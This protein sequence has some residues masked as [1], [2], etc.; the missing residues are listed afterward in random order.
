MAV[1][2]W[3]GFI[4][5]AFAGLGW[6]MAFHLSPP[7]RHARVRAWLLSWSWR[8]LVLP[9]A[10]WCVMNAGVSWALQPFMP[11]VQAARNSGGSWAGEYLRAVG[12]GLF[13][14]SSYWC[15]ISLAWVLGT[16][17]VLAEGE[18]RTDFRALCFTCLLTL[19]LPAAVVV[20]IGGMPW[21]GVAAIVLL[22]PLAGYA[23]ESLQPRQL[24]PMYARA[25]ARMKFGKY[26][27]AEWEIIR[28]LEKCE[29]DF[30]GWMML[31]DL[32]A[33]HFNDLNE[34]ESTVL[35]ICAQPKVSPS[36]LSV[37]LH[38]L[39][40][41]HLKL[42]QNPEAARRALQMICDRLPGTH[43]A[44][45]ARLRAGQLPATADELR[46]REAHKTIPLPALSD[47][48]QAPF[49]CEGKQLDKRQ[50]AHLANACVEQLKANPDNVPAREKLAR[51][52]AEQLGKADLGIEQLGLLL[53]MPGQPANRRADWLGLMAAWQI[54]YRGDLAA[55][56][57]VLERLLAEFAGT[58]QAFAA[59]RWLDRLKA[60][61]LAKSSVPQRSSP[62][63]VEP[64]TPS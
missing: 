37:A 23:P 13:I 35:E 50:A 11:E 30:E 56:G 58:P 7:D 40:D 61:A 6:F 5:T 64:G 55:G 53:G 32:Y 60:E 39:A 28:E 57:A 26:S 17:W 41:W 2:I 42:A 54:R 36:Q 16:A 63:R 1:L 59:R 19:L 52:F 47:S 14:I 4:G 44:H 46:E 24:P 34:A 27:E 18:S 22:A 12:Q 21:L 3:Y 31:A 43:L 10:L 33:T 9:L 25:V 51:L 48:L 45:M 20:L 38:R 49:P 8:G 62:L 15:G 29:D